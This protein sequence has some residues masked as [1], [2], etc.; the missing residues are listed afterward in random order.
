[1]QRP[2]PPMARRLAILVLAA[3]LSPSTALAE[4]PQVSAYVAR[5]SP[6]RLVDIISE[7]PPELTTDAHLAAVTYGHP[8]GDWL[9]FAWEVEGQL[10]RHWGEQSHYE[11]NA[12]WLARWQRFPWD[13]WVDTRIAGGHGLS[14]A[15]ERPPLEPRASR[16]DRDSTRLLTYLMAEVE[17]AAPGAQHWRGFLRVHH[18]SGVFGLHSGVR[19]GSN[20]V[21]LG[22]RYRFPGP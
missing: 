2:C 20:F 9:G 10:V 3:C 5:Y 21:G 12:L 15:T 11:F 19:G 17:V 1:V 14:Y 13:R 18:R 6:E 16:E 22:I 7:P 8:L 4:A